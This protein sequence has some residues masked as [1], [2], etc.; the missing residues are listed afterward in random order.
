MMKR[1]TGSMPWTNSDTI[2]PK[3]KDMIRV[4]IKGALR[5]YHTLLAGPL[6]ISLDQER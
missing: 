4:K 5:I 3:K 1:R 6:S 2:E